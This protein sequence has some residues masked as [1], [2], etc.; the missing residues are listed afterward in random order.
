MTMSAGHCDSGSPTPVRDSAAVRDTAGLDPA[1]GRGPAWLDDFLAAQLPRMVELRRRIHAN[2][3]LSRKELATTALVGEVLA[4]AGITSTR[5]ACGTGLVADLARGADSLV[6]MARGSGATEPPLIV[7]RA[8]MDALP[9]DEDTGLPF[10]S[11]SPGVSHACGHDVHTIVVLGAGLALA[12]APNLPARLR[13]IF[14]PAEEV[15]PGGAQDVVDAGLLA[16]VDLA[17]AVHCD[18]TLPAGTI[19]TRIGPITAS[20]DT[21]EVTIFG[22][23]G[24]TSRPHLT[25]DLVGALAA[26]AAHLPHLVA[27]HLPTQA[28]VTLA[29]G[30]IDAGGLG[31]AANVIPRRGR[32]LGT[33]RLVDRDAWAG[34]RELVERLVGDILA[35]YGAKFELDYVRGVPPTVNDAAAV[36]IARR[37]AEAALGEACLVQS[38]QSSGGEDF[39]VMLDAVPGAL[40]RLG[41]WDGAS[42]QVDLHTAAFYA[43]ERAIAVGI[44]TLAHTVLA[45]AA[46]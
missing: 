9:L 27:R 5:L 37:A 24:H 38:P 18:P 35:P 34:A 44:R 31:A 13:L 26:V 33:L 4:E 10:A 39:A 25:V 40:L 12:S 43:D 17:Y 3:E 19:G 1:A 41:V 32:L 2:P 30:A 11:T 42:E 29:W 15:F 16:G 7:L 28:G 20:C 14:Q 22:P 6:G 8:D 23:G 21:I 45:A 36:E 46:G